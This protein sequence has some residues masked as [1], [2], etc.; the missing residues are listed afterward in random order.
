MVCIPCI[1][2]PAF[3]WFYYRFIRPYMGPVLAKLEDWLAPLKAK[4]CPQCSITGVCPIKRP[5]TKLS[6]GVIKNRP[7]QTDV[8][9][10]SAPI[11]EEVEDSGEIDSPEKLEMVI[12]T[13]TFGV[14][15]RKRRLE[16]AHHIDGAHGAE[17]TVVRSARHID[18]A[19][20]AEPTVVRS[21]D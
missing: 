1:L 16:A 21:A 18:G 9:S 12:D 7:D 10:P 19:H 14:D 15:V 20:G 13:G 5:S 6:D 17:P 8:A 3:L 2:I 4:W 11:D